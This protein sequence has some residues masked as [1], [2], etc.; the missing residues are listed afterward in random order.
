VG[1]YLTLS[2]GRALREA[3]QRSWD[4]NSVEFTK[5]QNAEGVKGIPTNCTSSKFSDLPTA[6]PWDEIGLE[7]SF[8]S[9]LIYL[10]FLK[11]IYLPLK[12]FQEK[13]NP[14]YSLFRGRQSRW[15]WKPCQIKGSRN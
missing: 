11:I 9:H 7:T 8:V 14:H 13:K 15:V 4:L 3:S 6:S 1:E 5:Q 12:I 10:T 2:E